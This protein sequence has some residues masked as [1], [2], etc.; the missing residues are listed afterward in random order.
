MKLKYKLLTL[1]VAS[2]MLA[3]TAAIAQSGVVVPCVNCEQY[4]QRTEPFRGVWHNKNQT[5]QGFSIDVQN[6]KLFGIYYGY[7]QAGD[8]IWQ[9]FV[10]DLIPSEEVNIMWIVDA[11]LNQFSN[12][13]CFNC[14]AKGFDLANGGSIQVKF[15]HKNYA[16]I[17]I[18]GGTEQHFTP[19]IFGVE[20]IAD[21]PEQTEYLFPDLDGL[22]TFIYHVN[23]EAVSDIVLL[24]NQWSFT[25]EMLRLSDRKITQ[26]E[27]GI[28]IWYAVAS[29]FPP[30]EIVL[31]GEINCK[32]IDVDGQLQGPTCTLLKNGFWFDGFG[33]K[34]EFHFPP[35]GLGAY[36]I[37][38]ETLDGHTFEAIKVN[39]LEFNS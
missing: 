3:A 1:I 37:F 21:F 20:G 16:S 26:T 33:V 14:E 18:D 19:F 7:D 39:S 17:S 35:G 4:T 6:G 8:A 30:P 22:W 31:I 13:N 2:L 15:R 23:A 11:T 32:L 10:G 29:Y 12:S 25:S 28:E 34:R 36:R 24:G 5:A 38:G 9:T 27:D